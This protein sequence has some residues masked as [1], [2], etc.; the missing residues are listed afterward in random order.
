MN[1]NWFLIVIYFP[2]R[3]SYQNLFF[4]LH[5]CKLFFFYNFL[6]ELLRIKV[7]DQIIEVDGSSLV[8]V[9]Q[10]YAGAVLR[11]TNGL[12]HFKIGREKDGSED[13]EVRNEIVCFRMNLLF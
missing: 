7:N 2:A 12:V 4:W 5:L 3:F 9:T 8:G 11:N 6:I 13:S 10:A 1:I